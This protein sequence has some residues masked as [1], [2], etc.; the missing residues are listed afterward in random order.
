MRHLI[1]PLLL[2]ATLTAAPVLAQPGPSTKQ[3]AVESHLLPAAVFDGKAESWTIESRMAHWNVPGV[4]VAVI[5][6][7][8]IVW[9]KGYGVLAAGDPAPVTPDTRFQAASISKPIAAAAALSLVQDGALTLDGDI[10]AVLKRWKLPAG[11]FTAGR[12]VTLRHLLSHTGGLT[13]H[14]FAG[15]AQGA[16]VPTL[17]QVLAG[18]APANS[19]AIVSEARPGERCNTPAAA[20]RSSS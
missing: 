15:Y 20:T 13:V 18:A 8:K 5:D 7:G 16:P 1:L 4:S 6:D 17:V 19:A 3:Q 2:A 9:A 14:G 11:P 10:N 12:P